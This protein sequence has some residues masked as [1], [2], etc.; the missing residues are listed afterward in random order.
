MRL[1][2]RPIPPATGLALPLRLGTALTLAEGGTPTRVISRHRLYR[3]DA[4]DVAAGQSDLRTTHREIVE[5]GRGCWGNLV[6]VFTAMAHAA[7]KMGRPWALSFDG[8]GAQPPLRRAG[9]SDV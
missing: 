3:S 1:R 8:R 4:R 7:G 5:Q 2:G 6:R 9:A